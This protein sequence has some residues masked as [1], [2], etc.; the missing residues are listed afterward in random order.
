M[1]VE[2]FNKPFLDKRSIPNSN[3]VPIVSCAI[4]GVLLLVI[5]AFLYRVILFIPVSLND[6]WIRVRWGSTVREVIIQEKVVLSRG[7]LKDT[8]GRLLKKEGGRAPGVFVNGSEV[9]LS[10]VLGRGDRITIRP[11]VD[12]V[13]QVERKVEIIAPATY[14]SGQGAFLSLGSAGYPGMKIVNISSSNGRIIS[15]EII[16]PV[17]PV[18]LKRSVHTENQVVALTFDDG[19]SP[20]YTPQILAILQAEQV[21]ATFFIVGSQAKKY[22]SLI[23]DI[24]AAGCV[25]GNH[26]YTHSLLGDASASE[27]SVEIENTENIIK[28]ITGVGSRW[29]RP[30][31]GAMSAAIVET[32][33]LEGCKTVLWTIDPLDWMRPNPDALCD[34]VVSQVHPGAV[35]LLHDGGGDRAATV[36]ALPKIIAQLREKGYSFVRLD[37]I[38]G[39]Q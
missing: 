11:G 34:R 15:E 24:T 22:A 27:I 12:I 18:I 3:P 31:G 19:P 30:P 6:E 35:I 23:R 7:N 28:E 16:R 33:S 4:A 39:N 32:A 17:K 5:C 36:Q 29:F 1:K 13:E 2:F 14:V 10:T 21:P 37:E 38:V 9:S 20:T 8:Q 26:S 25:V